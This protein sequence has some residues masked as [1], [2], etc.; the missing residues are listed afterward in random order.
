M[1][2]PKVVKVTVW[3]TPKL[4][5]TGGALELHLP[6]Y[7]VGREGNQ[8]WRGEVHLS[9]PRYFVR[10]LLA[11]VAAMQIRD[12]ERLARELNRLT[13]EVEPVQIKPGT[14]QE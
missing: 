7:R 5:G 3:G 4:V 9:V 11:E 2:M 1:S 13:H 8:N 12:R 10:Q 6:S 14:S